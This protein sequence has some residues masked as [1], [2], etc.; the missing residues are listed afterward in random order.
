M[1]WRVERVFSQY[2][3]REVF[4]SPEGVAYVRVSRESFRPERG[5]V[6]VPV[7][8][9]GVGPILLRRRDALAKNL[10][11]LTTDGDIR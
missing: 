1:T 3:S 11:V 4:T 10:K 5:D 8:A 7:K 2:S 6:E 9:R